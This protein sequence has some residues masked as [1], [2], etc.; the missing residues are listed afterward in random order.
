MSQKVTS[1]W[2]DIG[3][4]I[5]T[6]FIS[7]ADVVTDI[8]VL[9]DFYNKERMVFFCI[10]LAILILAQCSYSW[11]FTMKFSTEESWNHIIHIL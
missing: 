10:S 8:I 7:I 9:I 5:L 1:A 4:D 6:I 3:Y 11:A 2:C